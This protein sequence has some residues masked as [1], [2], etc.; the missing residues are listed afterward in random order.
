VDLGSDQS[1]FRF[2]FRDS[3]DVLHQVDYRYSTDSLAH[4]AELIRYDCAG[5]PA[6]ARVLIIGLQT[7]AAPTL[8]TLCLVG[9]AVVPTSCANP[10]GYRLSFTTLTGRQ[11]TLDGTPRVSS[12]SLAAIG[13]P[14]PTAA[15]PLPNGLS[16]LDANGD[17]FID[18]V[19]IKYPS[20]PSSACLAPSAWTSTLPPSGSTL[21][22]P[23]KPAA[24]TI[25]LPY[26]TPTGPADTAASGFTLS[27]APPA[28]CALNPFPNLAPIDQ[29]RP[30]LVGLAPIAGSTP[31]GK[32][33]PGDS[34]RLTFSEPLDPSTVP[35]QVRLVEQN[36]SNHD[37]L[38]LTAVTGGSDLTQASGV[39]LGTNGVYLPLGTS[40]SYLATITAD[41]QTAPTV[42][43][44][45]IPAGA[46]CDTGDC[47]SF[48]ANAGS[49]YTFVPGTGLFDATP[50][51]NAAAPRTVSPLPSGTFRMY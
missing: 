14:T 19:V 23:V 17:G 51:Q 25:M 29:A 13:S 31:D 48:K 21:G 30:V 43:T 11:Y 42:L 36:V 49:A 6:T 32:P 8:T 18:Q 27:F 38:F 50:Q 20:D 45:A 22:A 2:D 33:D 28:G 39:D 41:S 7:P 40:A 44:V 37:R 4:R 16:M 46:A 35:T 12:G 24:N 10:V 15:D 34:F 47:T 26:A 5:G 3:S 1:V 9:G